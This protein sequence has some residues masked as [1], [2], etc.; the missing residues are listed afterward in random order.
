M[1]YVFAIFQLTSKDALTG[2][3]NRQAYKASV[4]ENAR[5][6]TAI[7][8]IDMNGLKVITTLPTERKP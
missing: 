4:R 1:Y 5:T 3:L 2:L 7:V 6:I 8:S